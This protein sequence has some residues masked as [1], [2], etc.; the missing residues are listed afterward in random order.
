MKKV[1]YYHY[2]SLQT[3]YSIISNDELWLS[4][5]KNSNDPNEFYLTCDEYNAYVSMSGKDPYDGK[6]YILEENGIYGN[7]YGISFTSIG[8]NL[9]QWERYGDALRGVSICLDIPLLQKVLKK[10]YDFSF[11][12]GSVKYTEKDKKRFVESKIK[13]V[14]LDNFHGC[15][16]AKWTMEA[17]YFIEHYN[18]AQMLFKKAAFR[19]EEE[20]RLFFDPTY[21]SFFYKTFMKHP[22]TE[23]DA[24]KERFRKRFATVSDTL[25]ILEKDKR[26]A[27][28]R[29]GINSYIPFKLS[30][31]GTQKAGLIKEIVLGP[32]CLQ[33]PAEL[34]DFLSYY[35]YDIPIIKSEI[36]IR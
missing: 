32:K 2:T 3:L 33:D 14:N 34:K 22:S 21:Y 36:S 20:Y 30:L 25:K 23:L 29:N 15:A 19:S 6:P 4:N 17:I 31:L 13:K 18:Q 7:T 12:F 9:S 5:L 16:I 11:D 1:N 28:M 10:K 26:F 27:I 35:G 24:A 8:D